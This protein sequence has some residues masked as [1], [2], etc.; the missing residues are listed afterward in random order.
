MIPMTRAFRFP[1]FR[2]AATAAFSAAIL[3]AS[4]PA[5]ADSPFSSWAAVVVA[6]DWRAHGGGTTQAF[7]NARRDVVARLFALGFTPGHTRQFSVL[8]DRFPNENVQKTDARAI[9]G[10]LG[11]LSREATGGCLV[12]FT[13]HGS[14]DG[15]VVGNEYLA[16]RD[17]ARIIDSTCGDRP[18]VIVLSACFSGVFVPALAA[19]SRMVLT[20]AREDRSSFGCGEA[21]RYP[22]FDGCFLSSMR[23][24]LDF[25]SLGRAVQDCVA[26]RERET[27]SSPPSEPQLSV[28]YSIAPVLRTYAFAPGALPQAERACSAETNSIARSPVPGCETR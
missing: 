10:A 15:I 13:S 5:R 12:Y 23:G 16:P 28:G 19:P 4:L 24:A 3:A 27:R 9:R 11:E 6:G 1:L 7:D 17:L 8:A 21:D 18:S 2:L 14:R 22:Y 25:P 20:A 26:E